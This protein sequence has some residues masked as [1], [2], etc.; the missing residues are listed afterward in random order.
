[1]RYLGEILGAEV[2]WDDAARTVT[3]TKG[4]DVVYLPS[5]AQLTL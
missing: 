5:A 4:D 1:M 3:L 2:V